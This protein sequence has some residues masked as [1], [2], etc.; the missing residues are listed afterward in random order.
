[1]IQPTP[2]P[3]L[4]HLYA[5]VEADLRVVERLF[6]EELVSAFDCVNQLCEHVRS[7]RGKMMRPALLLLAA[8]AC[9]RVVLAHRQLA[10][11]VEMVHMAT[12]VHDDV[13]D[14]ADQRR[15]QPT[16]GAMSGNVTAVLLGDYLISH[17]FHLCSGL[18]SQLASR[19]IGAT[20]NTVCEGELMQNVHTGNLRLT[21]EEYF[22]IIRRKTGALTAVSCEL[23][24]RFADADE[25]VVSALHQYGMSAGIAF[26]IV[27]DVLD[28][29][30]EQATVGKT[31]RLDLRGGKLTLPF[32]H[33][34]A[35]S[36]HMAD[37]LRQAWSNGRA[38]N[39]ALDGWLQ[40]SG[41]MEYALGVAANYVN[42]AVRQLDVL[43][44]SPARESLVG[45]AEFITHRRF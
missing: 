8:K 13:L 10:A 29:A 4:H 16:V 11:V 43:P 31:L 20:T 15:R 3:T 44:D 14:D 36:P 24:A 18:D 33:A 19:R 5:P 30:G 17:A 39:G 26:Q 7:Y 9:G 27:D 25:E 2:T 40:R 34:L 45:L 42:D 23:G 21:Q 6:D 37:S 1:M 22:E 12:L 35:Q 32:I 41:S 38:D 28:I